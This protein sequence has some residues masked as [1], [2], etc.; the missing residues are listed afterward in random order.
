M[1][2]PSQ[3]S[4]ATHNQGTKT[5]PNGMCPEKMKSLSQDNAKFQ[6]T[7]KWQ[8]DEQKVFLN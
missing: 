4:V 6:S 2:H 3:I 8:G 7:E 5:T 1:V